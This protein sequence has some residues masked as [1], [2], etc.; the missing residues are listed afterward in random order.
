[1]FQGQTPGVAED[2]EKYQRLRNKSG[3]PP[4][5]GI[6]KISVNSSIPQHKNGL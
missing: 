6:A 2:Y 4:I 5:Y 3:N 1:M